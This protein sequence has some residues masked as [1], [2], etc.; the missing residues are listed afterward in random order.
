MARTRGRRSARST[1]PRHGSRA[2]GTWLALKLRDGAGDAD[3]AESLLSSIRL[4]Q[5]DAPNGDGKG[6][7]ATS[8]D[9]LDSG[10]GDLYYA[11]LH[12]GATAWYLLAA[13][14]DNP[15]ALPVE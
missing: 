6:I 1:C 11:S 13:A 12:T 3:R 2:A 9:G 14:G 7:V 10:F 15:F 4:A 8:N 5:R